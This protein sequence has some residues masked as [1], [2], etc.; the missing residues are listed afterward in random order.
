MNVAVYSAPTTAVS[1]P[2]ISRTWSW[3][4]HLSNEL[5]AGLPNLLLALFILG[6]FYLA[7]LVVR[8]AINR[9]AFNHRWHNLRTVAGRVSTVVTILVGALVAFTVVAP[10]FHTGDVIKVL[11]LGSVAVEFAS[12]NILQ[13][14]VAG[15]LLLWTET[16]RIGDQI[17]LDGFEGTVEDIQ[18]RA[19]VVRM[20]G[21]QRI[22]IPNADLFTH[23]VIVNTA[24]GRR[25]WEYDFNAGAVNDVE[26]MKTA[27][28]KVVRSVE[29]VL[30]EPPPEVFTLELGDSAANVKL[31]VWWWTEPQREMV[32]THDRVMTAIK[33]RLQQLNASA[34]QEAWH[35]G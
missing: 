32:E 31:R 6:L 10:S 21:G 5:M 29:G 18:A 20:H 1:H 16:F 3:L 35:A 15:I 26:R 8:W 34:G 19:T 12:Q 24:F 14:F 4:H 27:L 17:K 33:A 22:V 9:L 7:S 30:P 25:R 13:N 2:E 23:S 28:V 11:G